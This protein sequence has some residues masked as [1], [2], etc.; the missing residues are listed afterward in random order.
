MGKLDFLIDKGEKPKDIEYIY[1]LDVVW[2]PNVMGDKPIKR[3]TIVIDVIQQDSGRY[4]FT[5][6]EPNDRLFN[7]IDDSMIFDGLC[8]NNYIEHLQKPYKQFCEWNRMLK[9]GANMVHQGCFG[10]DVGFTPFHILYLSEK[11]LKIICEKTGFELLKYGSTIAF[12]RKT[13]N[14]V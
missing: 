12:F 1:L 11:G 13:H 7:K 8:S 5:I 6:K 10:Y 4:D 9:V 14:L 2:T 3:G